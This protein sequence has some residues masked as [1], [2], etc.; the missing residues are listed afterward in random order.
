MVGHSVKNN[1]RTGGLLH[2]TTI[3]STALIASAVSRHTQR[4]IAAPKDFTLPLGGR[5]ALLPPI[6][7]TLPLASRVNHEF[8][9]GR[10]GAVRPVRRSP[11][12][13]RYARP[14]QGEG[15]GGGLPDR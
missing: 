13:P 9:R 12:S 11:P 1:A 14:S 7:F 10:G 5:A 6:D 4:G 8:S 15:E 3:F 2:E